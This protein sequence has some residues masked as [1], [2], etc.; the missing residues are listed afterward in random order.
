VP[1][2][3]FTYQKF[4][5]WFVSDCL[6]METLTIFYGHFGIF[7]A[8]FFIFEAIRCILWSF[9]VYFVVIW[10]IFCGNLVYILTFL[11]YYTKKNLA[12]LAVRTG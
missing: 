6:S 9:G 7:K 3:I 11:V 10:C 12:T 5:F 4:R 2:G 8:I 1:D